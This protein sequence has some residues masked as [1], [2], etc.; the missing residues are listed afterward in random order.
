MTPRREIL[1]S[2]P[3]GETLLFDEFYMIP[4]DLNWKDANASCSDLSYGE[5]ISF[6]KA[7]NCLSDLRR[8]CLEA[9][10]NNMNFWGGGGGE[11]PYRSLAIRLILGNGSY[12]R[13]P[14]S[15][16]WY[17]KPFSGIN[18]VVPK[19]PNPDKTLT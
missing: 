14:L 17:W 16:A 18:D 3:S 2:V 12:A 9:Y 6:Q 4:I 5:V 19:C 7:A 13:S 1:D 15:M 11:S 8:E 10:L